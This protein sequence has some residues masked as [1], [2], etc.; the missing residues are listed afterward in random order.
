MKSNRKLYFIIAGVLFVIHFVVFI[1]VLLIDG[2]DINDIIFQLAIYALFATAMFT[3]KKKL[4]GAAAVIEA[5]RCAIMLIDSEEFIAP[6]MSLIGA[7][8]VAISVFRQKKIK[9][10]CF[11]YAG[12]RALWYVLIMGDSILRDFMVCLAVIVIDAAPFVLAGVAFGG[13]NKVH[14][15]N[16]RVAPVSTTNQIEKLKNLK[17]LLDEG[18]LT[19]EEFEEKKKQILGL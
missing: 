6:A 2:V 3:Q 13:E 18:I 5:V 1:L 15:T 12:I 16:N 4:F 8:L 9:D 10:I 17:E 19:Q 14:S 11:L 7:I